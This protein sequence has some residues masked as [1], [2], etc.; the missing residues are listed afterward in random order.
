ML[1][2]TLLEQNGLK[3]YYA[4]LTCRRL[5]FPVVRAIIPGLEIMTD[6]DVFSRV[7]PRLYAHS[8]HLTARG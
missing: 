7:S 3:A 1:L 6:F 2:E 4:D 5:G 8:L